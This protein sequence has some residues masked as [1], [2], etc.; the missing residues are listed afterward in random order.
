[1]AG[2][3]DM[4]KRDGVERR[5]GLV[6]GGLILLAADCPLGLFKLEVTLPLLILDLTHS[7]PAPVYGVKPVEKLKG[8][9]YTGEVAWVPP[10]TAGFFQ[11]ATEYTANLT[12]YPA[13]GYVFTGQETFSTAARRK[14][15]R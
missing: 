7:I 5:R 1:M 6:S 4:K 14:F 9:G 11:P 8:E 12:F 10:A 13:E 15:R 2:R 3:K